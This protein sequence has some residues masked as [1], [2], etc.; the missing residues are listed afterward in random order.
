MPSAEEEEREKTQFFHKHNILL[1]NNQEEAYRQCLD[2]AFRL[3]NGDRDEFLRSADYTV[4][5]ARAAGLDVD[6]GG[7]GYRHD[8]ATYI[9]PLDRQFLYGELAVTVTDL[10]E[11][12]EQ[13]DR[14]RQESILAEMSMFTLYTH[15]SELRPLD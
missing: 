13:D 5:C 15:L 8:Y 4:K 12:V 3:K 1:S 14:S 10:K 7:K 11:A 6:M 2:L 9:P